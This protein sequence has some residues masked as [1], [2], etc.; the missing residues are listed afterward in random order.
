MS[1]RCRFRRQVGRIIGP[2][3]TTGATR[4]SRACG[5]P[6]RAVRVVGLQLGLQTLLRPQKEGMLR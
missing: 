4:R 6:C 1:R 3:P 5:G 2:S